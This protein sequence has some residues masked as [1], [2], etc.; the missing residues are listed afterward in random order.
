MYIILSNPSE[1][2]VEKI[3]KEWCVLYATKIPLNPEEK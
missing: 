3:M 2:H 1:N